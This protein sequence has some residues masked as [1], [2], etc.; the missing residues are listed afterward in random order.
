MDQSPQSGDPEDSDSRKKESDCKD[1]LILFYLVNES[2]LPCVSSQFLREPYEALGSNRSA[3]KKSAFSITMDARAMV[4]Q[5]PRLLTF[6][7][8]PKECN[9]SLQSA[10]IEAIHCVVWAQ[11]NSGPN[12]LVIA[13]HS[14]QVIQYWDA[15]SLK[16]TTVES[17]DPHS[18]RAV[19]DLLG[20]RI[21]PYWF[22]VHYCREESQSRKLEQWFR[23]QM[24]TPVTR[25]IFN[26]QVGQQ[27]PEWCRMGIAGE[28]ANGE[29]TKQM[30]MHT[31]LVLAF[32]QFSIKTAWQHRLAAQEIGFMKAL[33]HVSG[34]ILTTV[35]HY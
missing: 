15:D 12:I 22:S 23:E 18:H 9:I 19:K 31:G 28:G 16:K 33:R 32:K 29:I 7:S 5:P 35:S 3:E 26:Y 4:D 2:A 20:L 11:L 6:G 24:W 17:I 1:D 30:E 8:D 21:G 27:K 25:E 14:G 13:N 34:I 10:S